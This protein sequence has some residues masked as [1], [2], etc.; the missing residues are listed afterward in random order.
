VALWWQVWSTHPTAVTTCGCNDPALMQWFLAW[1]AAALAHGHSPLYSTALF[2]PD[3]INLL[4]N[5][6]VLALGLP[7]APVTWV[8][9]PVATLNVASTIG[10]ALSALAMFWLVRRWVDWAPAAFVAGLLFGFGPFAVANLAVAHLNTAILAL[11]PLMVGCLDEILVRQRRS[12]RVTGTALGG[13]VVL[14]FF[15]STE[16]L[17]IMALS[18]LIGVLLLLAYGA[19]HG[20]GELRRRAPHAWRGLATATALAALLLAFPVWFALEGPAHLSGLVWPTLRPGAGGIDL[21]SIWHL[22]FLDRGGVELY[23]GYLGPALPRAEYLGIGMLVV[24]GAGLLVWRRDRRLWFFGAMAVVATILSLGVENRTW[25]PWRLLAHVPL[26]RNISVARFEAVASLCVAIVLAVVVDHVHRAVIERARIRATGP[27]PGTD[28]APRR[29][30]ALVVGA[31]G[32]GALALGVAAVALVPVATAFV[33]TVPLTAEPVHVPRWFTGT[34]PRVPPGQVVLT[35]PPPSAGA[36]AMSW[37][38]IESMHFVLASGSGPQSIPARAGPAGAGLE[39]MTAAS[40]PLYAPSA[41][42]LRQLLG[43][44]RAIAHWGVTTIV[45]P[46]PAGLQPP[47]DRTAPTAFGLALFTEAEG[48]T[49]TRRDDAWVWHV[50]R[51]PLAVHPVS[52]TEFSRC[53]SAAEHAGGRLGAVPSCVRDPALT[54]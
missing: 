27:A 41:P 49:P 21:S 13:L 26:I 52:P 8:F 36:A 16:I 51:S 35:F 54:G 32:A 14:Q 48:T 4:S 34:D 42:S 20:Q 30:P 3:G 7:L 31:L 15:L 28:H 23:A 5:T 37:Q 46:D 19:A 6:G 17:L 2:P 43:V 44:R 47:F 38:A 50:G 1:P 25:V 45:V 22:R 40:L 12:W 10:P 39:L 29:T 9:G 18:V 33:G 53:V 11:L 24:L